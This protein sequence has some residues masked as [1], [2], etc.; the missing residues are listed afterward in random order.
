M[1]DD[2]KSHR[3]QIVDDFVEEEDIRHVNWP[4]KSSDLNPMEHVWDGLGIAIG[5]RNPI[6]SAR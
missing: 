5:Q 1:D 2:A 6:Y 4:S 3:A